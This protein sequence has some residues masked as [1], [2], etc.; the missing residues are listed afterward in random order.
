[1][2]WGPCHHPRLTLPTPRPSSFPGLG[3][4]GLVRQ[5]ELQFSCLQSLPS[6]EHQEDSQ[7]P[8]TQPGRREWIL[9]TTVLRSPCLEPQE[10][11]S[12]AYPRYSIYL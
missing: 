1:M 11:P 3:W 6:A 7:E 9:L 12:P 2:A 8:R 5:A 10:P 4:A